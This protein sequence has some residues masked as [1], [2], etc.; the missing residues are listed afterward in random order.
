[1]F[2]IVNEIRLLLNTNRN[3]ETKVVVLV[4]KIEKIQRKINTYQTEILVLLVLLGAVC[5]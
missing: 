5:F 3:Y 2:L 4:D 1:M